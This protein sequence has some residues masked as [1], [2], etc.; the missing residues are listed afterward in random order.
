V[1]I[2]NQIGTVFYGRG[3]KNE[4][5]YTPETWAEWIKTIAG[6]SISGGYMVVDNLADI[7]VYMITALK[8]STKYLILFHV[9]TNTRTISTVMIDKGLGNRPF[10]SDLGILTA[11][12][13]GNVKAVASTQATIVLNRF[14]SYIGA[15]TGK[16]EY[17]QWRAFE[18]PADSEISSDADTLSADQLAAKY[19]FVQGVLSVARSS[20]VFR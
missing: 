19:L 14:E 13:T 17:G 9:K 11:G 8:P 12:Q 6:T 3:Y 15:N 18:C 1:S 5:V 10:A 20:K 7:G 4:L 16:I 2:R